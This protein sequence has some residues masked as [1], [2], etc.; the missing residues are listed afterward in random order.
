MNKNNKSF[1]R[2]ADLSLSGK[3]INP[4]ECSHKEIL[5]GRW[6]LEN[7]EGLRFELCKKCWLKLR[8]L[9]GFKLIES[10]YSLYRRIILR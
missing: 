4:R 8:Y 6:I 1:P 3:R 9:K 10:G 7:E 5:L 2:N